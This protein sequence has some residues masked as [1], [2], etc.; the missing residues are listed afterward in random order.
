MK[1]IAYLLK[2]KS[3]TGELHL[4]EAKVTG[5]KKCI[6]N[7]TSICGKMIK[8]ESS[9]NKFVCKDEDTARIICAEIGRT[10][11]GN[12]VSHLYTTDYEG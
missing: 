3:N 12:C 11:C 10:V 1:K 2:M 5:D 7:Y 9:E 4:F 8:L 6:S